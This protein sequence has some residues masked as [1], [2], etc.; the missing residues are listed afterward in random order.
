MQTYLTADA[1]DT[2]TTFQEEEIQSFEDLEDA[3]S[4][5]IKTAYLNSKLDMRTSQNKIAY[6]G[7]V[8]DE[9]TGAD[10]DNYS[11]SIQLVKRIGNIYHIDIAIKLPSSKIAITNSNYSATLDGGTAISSANDVS[12]NNTIEGLYTGRFYK[13]KKLLIPN[14]TEEVEFEATLLIGGIEYPVN[15]LFTLSNL[16]LQQGTLL[17]A[18][19]EDGGDTETYTPPNNELDPN[20][21]YKY[22]VTRLGIADYRRVEQSVCCYLPGEVSHIENV[23]AKEFKERNTTRM[24]RSESSITVEE[25]TETEN[26]TDTTSTDRNEVNQEIAKMQQNTKDFNASAGIH[27]GFGDSYSFDISSS[28]AMHN[29]KE[30]SN[31]MARTEARELTERAMER[32]VTKVRAER[33]NKIIDEYTEENRHGFDNTGDNAQ[34][35]SGVYRWVDVKYKNEIYNYGKRLMY[36]FMIPEPGAFHKKVNEARK[37]VPPVNLF[38][39]PAFTAEKITRDNYLTY[40]AANQTIV[41]APPDEYI[42]INDSFINAK[43]NE[44]GTGIK[45]HAI[46]YSIEIPTNYTAYNLVGWL[47]MKSGD[48]NN[49]HIAGFIYIA[50]EYNYFTDSTNSVHYLAQLVYLSSTYLQ[51]V[52]IKDHLKMTIVTWDIGAWNL[53]IVVRCKLTDSAFVEWQNDT[54]QK[55]IDSYEVKLQQYKDELAEIENQEITYSDFRNIEQTLLRKNCISYLIGYDTLGKNFI[56]DDNL[57]NLKV[58]AVTI[59]EAGNPI[60]NTTIR[61]YGSMVKFVEQAFE[62]DL[63]SYIFYPFYW[64]NKSNWSFLYTKQYNDVLF[65]RF[66]QSGM[67]RVVV[68]IRPGFEDAVNWFMTTGQIWNGLNAPVIGDDLYLSIVDELQNPEYTIE[69]SWETRMPT[70]LTILQAKSAGLEVEKALPCSCDGPTQETLVLNDS[71]L[72]GSAEGVGHWVVN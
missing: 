8:I 27:G 31:N 34:H 6:K 18:T 19:D 64:A 53:N 36:E 3:I 16:Q 25:A 51:T 33:V 43:P 46:D 10:L 29:S 62:W 44:D 41:N 68:T 1:Y 47:N 57:I 32:V 52:N 20:N 2:F 61:D 66:M 60:G 9:A 13:I 69:G 71:T 5:K 48:H 40:A 26:L 63:M 54:Y 55:L 37:I 4:T 14:T 49:L 7:I 50:G 38:A 11:Y 28:F 17:A 24:R 12:F 72:N 22:G 21:P 15:A 58:S 67:A 59:D 39:D 45:H 56:K 35:I 70:S 23:M 30:E 42:D 65:S